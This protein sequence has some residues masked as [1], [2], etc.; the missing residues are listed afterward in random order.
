LKAFSFFYVIQA[1]SV[2]S[3]FQPGHC[4]AFPQS[5][6]GLSLRARHDKQRHTFEIPHRA[7]SR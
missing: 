2:N 5:E 6:A 3:L 7:I 4:R 1:R